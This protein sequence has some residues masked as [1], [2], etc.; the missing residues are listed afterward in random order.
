MA[1]PAWQQAPLATASPGKT[2]LTNPSPTWQAAPL[3]TDVATDLRNSAVSGG[4]EGLAGLPG[5]PGDILQATSGLNERL[6]LKPP[7]DAGGQ[8]FT[9]EMVGTA[10][11]FTLTPPTTRQ[12]E[13]S[14]HFTPYQPQTPWGQ[15]AHDGATF[16]PGAIAG[17]LTGGATAIPWAAG[18]GAAMGVASNA[19]GRSVGNAVSNT[20]GAIGQ[21]TGNQDLANLGAELQPYGQLAGA[22]LGG[23]GV[24]KA[25]ASGSRAVTR[26]T[27]PTTQTIA[28]NAQ[29]MY[30]ASEKAGILVDHSVVDSI[31]KDVIRA[32]LD[33]GAVP[34]LD[35]TKNAWGAIQ[36]LQRRTAAGA[37]MTLKD[38]DEMRQIIAQ[39]QKEGSA[40][41]TAM[42]AKL[43]DRMNALTPGDIVAGADPLSAV[44]YL[45][46]A[47]T[48]WQQKSKA[49][50]LDKIISD[51]KVE[52]RAD[53]P[54]AYP[55]ALQRGFKAL[56]KDDNFTKYWTPDEQSAILAASKGGG[57]GPAL[58]RLAGKTVGTGGIVPGLN[59]LGWGVTGIGNMATTQASRY[60]DALVRNPNGNV[61]TSLLPVPRTTGDLAAALV[62]GTVPM[63]GGLLP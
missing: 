55:A 1:G 61:F 47:R 50:T 43:T 44:S 3:A 60:A 53:K 30:A 31:A 22:V 24:S 33:K 8:E 18:R 16:V 46:N 49:E 15:I 42:V 52:Q 35:A 17:A 19:V 7:T 13:Q 41:S 28:N 27:A 23:W 56:A 5:L 2:I 12:V 59:I 21:A 32:G 63:R 20:A 4:L 39:A 25:G 9:N 48:L 51:A 37:P 38:L 26:L 10:P 14:F 6:G 40:A 62:G 54:G 57:V 36:Y 11:L 58:I 34:E 29:Q 45:N